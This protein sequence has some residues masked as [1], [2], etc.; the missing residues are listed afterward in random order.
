MQPGDNYRAV[1][2]VLPSQIID[3]V[4]SSDE[5]APQYL[6][7]EDTQK[8]NLPVSPSLTVWRQLWLEEDS[9]SSIPLDVYGYKKNNLPS[10][11]VMPQ[12][13][14]SAQLTASGNTKLFVNS[15]DDYSSSK[16]LDNAKIIVNSQTYDVETY[17][18][19]TNI[20]EIPGNHVND[21]LP[22]ME[23]RLYDDD[24]FGV[25]GDIFPKNNAYGS[26]KKLFTPAFIE[27]K[28]ASPY[29]AT[30]YIPFYR[31]HGTVAGF[32]FFWHAGIFA[33]ALDLTS[34]NELWVA[35]L[36]YAYQGSLGDDRD[37]NT[38]EAL[39]GGTP[40]NRRY[41]IVYCETVREIL[42]DVMRFPGSDNQS[43]NEILK[44]NIYLTGA[45]EIGHMPGSGT[46]DEHHSETFLMEQGY[47]DDESE[48]KYSPQTIKRFRSTKNWQQP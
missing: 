31:N 42:D 7:F 27:L 45:H 13:I 38:E 30:K 40:S 17:A 43:L 16:N 18:Q 10:L 48:N 28:D 19:S 8:P 23:F 6:G 22:N 29:N 5:S 11:G 1:C 44:R 24:D 32:P 36:L 21:I 9:I 41:S 25:I 39:E 34:S 33:D 37:P 3:Q 46:E 20:F 15:I 47:Q 26:I 35:N 2:E 14:L 12:V 4:Q